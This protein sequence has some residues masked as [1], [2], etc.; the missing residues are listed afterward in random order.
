LSR[1]HARLWQD[2]PWST[3]EVYRLTLERAREIGL[4][5]VTL[6]GW[7]DVDDAASYRVIEDEC[8]G[9]PPSCATPHLIGA[10]AA[11]TF[12]FIRDRQS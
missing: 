9:I 6:P 3:S 7:Y 11:A 12:R 1:P 2:M 10:P 8:R 4:P 5:V